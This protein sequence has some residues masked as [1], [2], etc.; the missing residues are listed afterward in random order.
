ML[1]RVKKI[2]I[3]LLLIISNISCTSKYDLREEID[4]SQKIVEDLCTKKIIFIGENHDNV[5]PIY[6]M[7]ENLEKFYNAG[8]RYVFLETGDDGVLQD[9]NIHEYNFSIVPQ[10]GLYAWKYEQQL[11]ELEINKINST[12]MDDPIKVIWPEYQ[13]AIPSDLEST[14]ILNLRD[15]HIQKSVISIMNSS[16]ANEKAIIFYGSG[17]GAKQISE[18][19]FS[20][21]SNS[22][23]K[24]TGCYLSDY[25]KNDFVSYH[26]NYLPSKQIRGIKSDSVILSNKN[27]FKYVPTEFSNLYDYECVSPVRIYGITYPYYNSNRNI[28][29]LIKKTKQFFEED[30]NKLSKWEYMEGLLAVYYLKYQLNENFNFSYENKELQFT[31][32]EEKLNTKLVN[33]QDL[34]KYAENLYSYGWIEDYLF[35][36]ENDKR[37]N[38]ILYN[39]KKAKKLDSK[40]IWPQYWISYFITE[41]AIYSKKK[42]DYKKAEKEWEVL[43]Q[44]EL[45]YTS[46]VLKLAYQKMAFCAEKTG[47]LGKAAL[48]QH[49]ADNVNSLL[50]L[51]YESYFYFGW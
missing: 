26:F 4:V 38:Y 29:V 14:D 49:K 39:M 3:L 30:V 47:D 22:K 19:K 5:Y 48:Y 2:A 33:L 25:Y 51:D 11:L 18:Y 6:F 42:S 17:H 46:P 15:L 8:L 20:S 27:F 41:K 12:H 7:K 43:F 40:D 36:P 9:S 45:L 16:K 10:W 13:L 50:D 37:I 32:K 23:W 1:K 31:I 21:S 35:S 34:E 24:M 28:D 44:N